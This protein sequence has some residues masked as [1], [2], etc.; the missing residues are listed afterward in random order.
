MLITFPFLCLRSALSFLRIQIS[1]NLIISQVGR[2][3]GRVKDWFEAF[4]KMPK[5]VPKVAYRDSASGTSRAA[6]S[7]LSRWGCCGPPWGRPR[8]WA[9]TET[10][11]TRLHIRGRLDEWEKNYCFTYWYIY[12]FGLASMDER[13][14]ILYFFLYTHVHLYKSKIV[15][16]NKPFLT[17]PKKGTNKNKTNTT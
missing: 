1:D 15:Y 3:S 17:P 9:R 11:K 7:P 14:N 8:C 5:P 10:S 4:N 13:E 2:F 16:V 12:I 6:R